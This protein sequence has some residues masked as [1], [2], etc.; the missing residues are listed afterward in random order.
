LLVSRWASRGEDFWCEE[1]GTTVK[2]REGHITEPVLG[3]YVEG[4]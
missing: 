2:G 3:S 4:E 1:G